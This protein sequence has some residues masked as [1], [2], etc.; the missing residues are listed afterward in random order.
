M[1][2]KEGY[3]LEAEVG[4]HQDCQ[5]K[6]VDAYLDSGSQVTIIKQDY[7][8]KLPGESDTRRASKLLRAFN[9]KDMG[10]AYETDLH[11]TW[12]GGP[13]IHTVAFICKT[14][15][16]DLLIGV[17]V[18]QDYRLLTPTKGIRYAA[19]ENEPAN[20]RPPVKPTTDLRVGQIQAYPKDTRQ[21]GQPTEDVYV[22]LISAESR[23]RSSS[24]Q[25]GDSLRKTCSKCGKSTL[26][27]D[28]LKPGKRP[29]D[30]HE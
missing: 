14:L 28:C 26:K 21:E 16:T 15:P 3:Y 24:G 13:L 2:K 4:R 9:G 23:K 10:V 8:Q 6:R 25:A 17:Q 20:S 1:V 29:P 11:I 5:H 18:I 7:F 19:R 27:C 12:K 22:G 30:R